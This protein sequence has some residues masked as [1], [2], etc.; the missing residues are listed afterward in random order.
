MKLRREPQAAAEKSGIVSL[1]ASAG[2]VPG[3]GHCGPHLSLAHGQRLGE[4]QS[5][6]QP[7]QEGVIPG[8]RAARWPCSGASGRWRATQSGLLGKGKSRNE[9][10]RIKS[11]GRRLVQEKWK[12]RGKG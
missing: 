2:V 9:R 1:M 12:D 4:Q 3:W 7:Q 11:M 5:A 8:E 6:M 10:G